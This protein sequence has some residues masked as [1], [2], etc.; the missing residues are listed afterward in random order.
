MDSE[1]ETFL[2]AFSK[3]HKRK[4]SEDAS[5]GVSLIEGVSKVDDTVGQFGLAG[6]LITKFI[7]RLCLSRLAAIRQRAWGFIVY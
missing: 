1:R 2:S 7:F 6:Q 5:A 3:P 4:R